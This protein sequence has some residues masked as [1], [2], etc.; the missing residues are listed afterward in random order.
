MCGEKVYN[1]P[2]GGKPFEDLSGALR[3][4]L[5][6]AELGFQHPV[7]GQPMHFEMPLPPDLAAF[8]KQLR[9]AVGS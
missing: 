1:K 8:L 4:A 9:G 6:A 5:H 2:L 7:T 3:L